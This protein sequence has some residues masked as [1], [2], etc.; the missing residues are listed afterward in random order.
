MY[1]EQHFKNIYHNNLK[2]MFFSSYS[3]LLHMII[4]LTIMYFLLYYVFTI[5]L[6]KVIRLNKFIIPK[7]LSNFVFRPDK[8]VTFLSLQIFH[9][10][11]FSL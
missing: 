2:L 1:I 11:S 8:N 3:I 7:K 9:A 4:N 10:L 5:N 6:L